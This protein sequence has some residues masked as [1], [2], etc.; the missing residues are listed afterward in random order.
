MHVLCRRVWFTNNIII[1]VSCSVIAIRTRESQS[2]YC[3]NIIIR[4]CVYN[5][6]IVNRSIIGCSLTIVRSRDTIVGRI[7]IRI[8]IRRRYRM[9][10][11]GRIRSISRN[12]IANG[13]VPCSRTYSQSYS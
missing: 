3:S 5:R 9:R 1:A 11:L 4:K 6:M 8:H 2:S 12:R 10:I 13:T 7:P